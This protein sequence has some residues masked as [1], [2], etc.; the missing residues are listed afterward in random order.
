MKPATHWV[1][2]Q[3]AGSIVN[4][5]SRHDYH[6]DRSLGRGRRAGC[7]DAYAIVSASGTK[8]QLPTATAIFLSEERDTGA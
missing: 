8:F 6:R 4:R 2:A 5:S 1:Y 3:Y 7:S